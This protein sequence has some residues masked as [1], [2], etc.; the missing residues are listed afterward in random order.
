MEQFKSLDTVQFLEDD[1]NEHYQCFKLSF[2]SKLDQYQMFR[3]EI[4]YKKDKF[5]LG[6]WGDSFLET[7][8]ISPEDYKNIVFDNQNLLNQ[9]LS[10]LNS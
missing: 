10:A 8:K 4:N 1:S 9:E 3:L 5:S 7:F 2:F 6:Q